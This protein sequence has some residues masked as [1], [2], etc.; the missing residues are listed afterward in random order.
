VKYYR[1]V[2]SWQT[3]FEKPV[4]FLGKWQDSYDACDHAYK[5][6]RAD[7][8]RSYLEIEN[9]CLHK[10]AN[11]DVYDVLTFFGFRHISVPFGINT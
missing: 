10:D 9:Q 11:Y 5:V 7:Q 1:D 4:L 2:E 3:H 8:E 6:D